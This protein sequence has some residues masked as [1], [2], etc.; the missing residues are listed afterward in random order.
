VKKTITI[1]LAWGM[2]SSGAYATELSS[3]A[4]SEIKHLL[5]YLS[6]SRCEFYRNGNWYTAE[7]ARAHLEKKYQYLLRKQVIGSAEDFISKAATQSSMS[8]APYRVRCGNNIS[9]S[10]V[11]LR[12]ELM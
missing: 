4:Q 3:T 8:G 11:W 5:D 6:L 2:L 7:A 10:A 12:A 1:I 9:P